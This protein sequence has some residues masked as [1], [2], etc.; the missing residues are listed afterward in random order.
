MAATPRYLPARRKEVSLFSVDQILQKV[1]SFLCKYILLIKFSVVLKQAVFLKV[2]SI[3]FSV[4]ELVLYEYQMP[5]AWSRG[6]GWASKEL[7]S[8]SFHIMDSDCP[9]TTYFVI[10]CFL[11]ALQFF[12]I[13]P[14]QMSVFH[15]FIHNYVI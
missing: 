8:I 5:L 14:V 10:R 11:S 4:E 1:L 7:R 6:L 2:T 3:F 9:Q 13:L 15:V 12:L